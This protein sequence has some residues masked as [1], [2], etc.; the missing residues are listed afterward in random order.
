MTHTQ[1]NPSPAN[2]AGLTT[3]YNDACPVCSG[4]INHYRAVAADSDVPLG[5][6]DVA[7]ERDALAAYG[8]TQDMAFRRLYAVDAEGR[9]LV[10]LDAFIAIWRRLPQRRWQWLA[11]LVSLPVVKPVSSVLYE[12]VAARAIYLWNKRRLRKAPRQAG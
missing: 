10:G 1:S 11:T 2:D 5:W 6:V 9:L 7:T 3:Y 12:H 4:E 8:I